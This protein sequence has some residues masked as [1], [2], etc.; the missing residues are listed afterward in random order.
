MFTVNTSTHNKAACRFCGQTVTIT[1][2]SV[3]IAK[4]HPRPK[5]DLRPTLVRKDGR[6]TL[7]TTR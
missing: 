2:M 4:A 6:T 5:A 1:E 7:S 3:H